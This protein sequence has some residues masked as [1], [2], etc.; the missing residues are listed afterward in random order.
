MVR[1]RGSWTE[2]ITKGH[3]TYNL[4]YSDC[5]S[6]LNSQNTPLVNVTHVPRHH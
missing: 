2:P 5:M 3:Y 1:S 6:L 4:N